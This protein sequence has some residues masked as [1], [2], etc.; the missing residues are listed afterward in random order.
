MLSATM[1]NQYQQYQQ[2]PQTTTT[3]SNT[4]TWNGSQ[5]VP[6]QAAAPPATSSNLVQQYT[7]YY[8]GWT[9][10]GTDAWSQYYADQAS[11]AAHYFHQNP[12]ATNAPFELP[13]APPQGEMTSYPQPSQYPPQQYQPQQSQYPNNYQQQQ[14]PPSQPY[15]QQPSQSYQ[16]PHSQS[17]QHQ[18]PPAY[19]TP[20]AQQQQPTQ[21]SASDALKRYVDRC[22]QHSNDKAKTMEQ[23]QAKMQEAMQQG[24]FHSADYWE[25]QSL[26]APVVSPPAPP[27]SSYSPA[28]CAPSSQ[29]VSTASSYYHGQ[30]SKVT[31][32]TMPPSEQT[33]SGGYYGPSSS[34]PASSSVSHSTSYYGPSSATLTEPSSTKKKEDNYYGAPQSTKKKQKRASG[35]DASNDVLSSRAH[36]FQG[37]GGLADAASTGTTVSGFDKYMGK[38]TIGGSGKVLDE[39]DFERMTVKGT[40]QTLEKEYLRLT[41]PPRAELVRPQPILE[42][43]LAN[44]KADRAAGRHEYLWFCSQLKAIRQD[45]TVQR[46]Q[47]A[48]TVDVY[49]THARIALEEDDWNEYNQSQTQLKELYAQLKDDA[50]AMKNR[51]EFVAYRLLYYVFLTGN[52][53]YD[54]GSSDLLKIMITLT[55]EQRDDPVIAHA[56]R[57]RVAYTSGDYHLFFQLRKGCSN[58]GQ[59]LMDRMVPSMRFSALQRICRAYRPTVEVQ[60]ALQELGF[61]ES[62]SDLGKAWLQSCGCLLNDDETQILAKDSVIHESDMEDKQSLI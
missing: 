47:N 34:T 18:Q 31:P 40:C 2:Q 23:V 4:H 26:L 8:H 48:F 16:Q 29:R 15:Q 45:C 14:H 10:H 53:K 28:V 11:R 25:K 56:L 1:Y 42:R 27:V 33:G 24:T 19:Q 51:N 38:A 32:V 59:H 13:P 58:H 62:A 49:E 43:H 12:Q 50:V 41:A 55:P 9:R 35:F 5:W 39:N 3:T 54:G 57:V 36:R 30:S 61:P 60:F 22:L 44:I 17:Y 7:D 20:A 37:P 52:E 21:Q 6:N 46:I